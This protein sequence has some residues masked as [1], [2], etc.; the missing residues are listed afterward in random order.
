M[1][2]GM[3]DHFKECIKIGKYRITVHAFERLIERNISLDEIE[4]GILFGEVIEDY[5]KGKYGPSSLAGEELRKA[6]SCMSSVRWSL[7]GLLQHTPP[8]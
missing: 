8:R 7:Y 4:E 3:M 1:A 5:P 2:L 6:V